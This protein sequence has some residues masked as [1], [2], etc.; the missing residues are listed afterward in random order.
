ME[1]AIV[2]ACPFQEGKSKALR[3][4]TEALLRGN[5]TMQIRTGGEGVPPFVKKGPGVT[6]Y[7]TDP[8]MMHRPGHSLQFLSR[9]S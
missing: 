7:E 8:H 4:Q 3:L 6:P 5:E 2:E 9:S 1:T